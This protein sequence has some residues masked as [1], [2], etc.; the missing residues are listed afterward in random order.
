MGA[1]IPLREGARSCVALQAPGRFCAPVN[2]FVPENQNI[3]TPAAAFLDM[4]FAVSMA[5]F[6]TLGVGRTFT[7]RFFRV[8]RIDVTVIMTRMTGF[9]GFHATTL[10][11]TDGVP[12][13][14]QEANQEHHG[15][16]DKRQEFSLH[17]NPLLIRRMQQP[18]S[19]RFLAIQGSEV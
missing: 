16:D 18:Y 6:T 4:G 5:G 13:N 3:D 15:K 8:G 14:G 11:C 12:G 10:F 1:H 2:F 17:C 19:P 9:A 7:D